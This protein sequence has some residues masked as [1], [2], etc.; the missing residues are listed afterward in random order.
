MLKIRKSVVTD[1][2]N[3]PIAVQV[4]IRTFEKMEQLL[5]D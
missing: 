5:E 3:K 4:D 1:N 2:N